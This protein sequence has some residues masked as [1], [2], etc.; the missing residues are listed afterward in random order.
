MATCL[1]SI[2]STWARRLSQAAFAGAGLVLLSAGALAAQ[3]PAPSP[4][5]PPSA[6]PAPPPPTLPP[7]PELA[8]PSLPAGT[9]TPV[10]AGRPISVREAITIAFANQPQLAVVAT[11]V[12]AAAGRTQQAVSGYYP[13]A[14]L[15][16]QRTQSGSNVEGLGGGRAGGYSTT[17]SASQLLY[18]FGRTPA[19][20]G[21]ARSSQQAAQQGY[22]QAQQ[23]VVN[24]VKQAYYTLLQSQRLV[25]VQHSNVAAQQAHLELTQARFKVGLAPHSDVVRAQTAVSEAIYLLANAE[26]AAAVSRANLNVVMGVDARAPTT[27]AEADE[28]APTG[29]DA[30][31]PVALALSRRPEIAQLRA[32]VQ[33]AQQGVKLARTTDLPDVFADASYGLSGSDLP[34][35]VRSWSYGVALQWPFYSDGLTKGRVQEAEASLHAAQETLRQGEQNVGFEVVQASLNVQTAEQ[36]VISSA[37]QVTSAEETVAAATGR[38]QAGVAAYIEVIDAQNALLL[39]QVNQVNAQYGLSL[40]RAALARALG[41]QEY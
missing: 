8:P 2:H 18:D 33:A 39:A 26:N 27:V 7:L 24:D 21:Q 41:T 4:A 5:A 34:P 31:D 22:A 30:P 12:Q 28:P 37:A 9:P 13:T 25:E 11:T 6:T 40:A 15:S 35:D 38:Y 14:S 36:N 10:P 19:Q 23:D 3:A 1:C 20:V 16:A 32:S 29:A 17:V